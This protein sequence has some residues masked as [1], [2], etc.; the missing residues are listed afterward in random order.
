MFSQTYGTQMYLKNLKSFIILNNCA[1]IDTTRLTRGW[2]Y[3]HFAQKT[4]VSEHWVWHSVWPIKKGPTLL[5]ETPRIGYWHPKSTK[6]K[7]ASECLKPETNF[8]KLYFKSPN[9]FFS[10]LIK[11]CHFTAKKNVFISLKNLKLTMRI[12]MS[13]S[14]V[15]FDLTPVSNTIKLYNELYWTIKKCSS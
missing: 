1:S 5:V 14:K 6:K 4:N 3:Q 10:F 7:A 2:F 13:K 15:W 8:T 11:F 12:R 9:F